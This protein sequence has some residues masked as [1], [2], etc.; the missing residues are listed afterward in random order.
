LSKPADLRL[1]KKGESA[2]LI[3]EGVLDWFPTNEEG[4]GYTL[5]WEHVKKAFELHEAGLLGESVMDEK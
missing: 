1:K 5:V 3:A 4:R 2:C